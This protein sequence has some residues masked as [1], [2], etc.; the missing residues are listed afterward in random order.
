MNFFN[1][2][3]FIFLIVL[4]L[5]FGS[6]TGCVKKHVE[7]DYPRQPT[8]LETIGKLEAIGTVIGC[9]FDPGPCQ[10]KRDEQKDVKSEVQ[11]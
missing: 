9:M 7:M 10:K 6:L 4:V 2:K 8:T 1:S 11:E 3:K 5:V